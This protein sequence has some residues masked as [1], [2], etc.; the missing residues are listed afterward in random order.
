M[1]PNISVSI[2]HFYKMIFCSGYF[3]ESNAQG[4]GDGKD[5]MLL[6]VLLTVLSVSFIICLSFYGNIFIPKA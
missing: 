4:L 6:K 2:M 3:K 1:F 5:R